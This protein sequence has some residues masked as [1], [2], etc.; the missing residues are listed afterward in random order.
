ML[1]H[2]AYTIFCTDLF[3]FFFLYF[4]LTTS[5]PQPI[6][7]TVISVMPS[8]SF[9]QISFTKLKWLLVC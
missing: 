2:Q 9:L 1:S 5:T 3:F 8:Q 4:S 7:T 6:I